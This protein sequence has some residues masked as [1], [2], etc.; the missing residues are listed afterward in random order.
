MQQAKVEAEEVLKYHTVELAN[1]AVVSDYVKDLRALL[2]ESSIIPQKAFL[3]SFVDRIEVD[4]TDARVIYT[5]PVPPDDTPPTDTMPVLPIVPQGPPGWI[6]TNK[7][8][9]VINEVIKEIIDAVLITYS[10][11]SASCGILLTP[12]VPTLGLRITIGLTF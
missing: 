5:M 10:L 7:T 6:R 8:Y 1:R 12:C 2:E 9:G 3:R 4:D 11:F